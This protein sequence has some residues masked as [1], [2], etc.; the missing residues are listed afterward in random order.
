MKIQ[1][2]KY[3][4]NPDKAQI[5]L[6][7]YL[8]KMLKVT[9][10]DFFD[11]KKYTTVEN[12][13]LLLLYAYKD[14][15]DNVLEIVDLAWI[16]DNLTNRGAEKDEILTKICFAVGDLDYFYERRNTNNQNQQYVDDILKEM[17][18]YYE[19]NK[20]YLK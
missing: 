18:E 6:N 3:E 19:K 8:S 13:R 10:A 4:F 20:H 14:F 9:W 17:G 1:G 15:Q 11:K 5:R 7:F 2:N 16:A 12:A